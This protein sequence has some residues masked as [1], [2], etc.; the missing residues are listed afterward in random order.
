MPGREVGGTPRGTSIVRCALGAVFGVAGLWFARSYGLAYPQ[1]SAGNWELAAATI[2]AIWNDP[3]PQARWTIAGLLCVGILALLVMI[4][5]R[6]APNRAGLRVLAVWQVAM[7]GSVLGA[8]LYTGA[9]QD[10]W[11]LRYLVAPCTLA[12][13]LIA[14]LAALQLGERRTGRALNPWPT[15]V[16]VLVI[17]A[18]VIGLTTHASA[19]VRTSYSAPHRAAAECVAALAERE[20]SAVLA[21]YWVAKPI[22][23]FSDNR[24][25]VVPVTP[26]R[27][28]PNFW[29]ASRGWF[30]HSQVYGIAITNG[31]DPARIIE[32]LGK[33]QLVDHCDKY[34][35]WV[36]RD[37]PRV[38]MTLR[39]QSIFDKELMGIDAERKL[40]F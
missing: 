21:E 32:L 14:G 31:L 2:T 6:R 19:L 18:L 13:V 9:H 15:R 7:T 20:G 33:P 26:G 24:A 28:K 12:V 35:L 17:V 36:Y 37:M 8:F 30:R 11:T 40:G 27:M 3:D 29:I 5:T 39:M 16:A 25:H 38:H 1:I 10:R 23:L 22:M 4:V 34:E